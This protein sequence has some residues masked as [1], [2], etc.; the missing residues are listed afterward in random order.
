MGFC[1]DITPTCDTCFEAVYG[2]CNDVLIISLS[3]TADTTFYV[4]L[5]DKFDIITQLT[6]VTDSNGDFTITQTWT[7]YAGAMEIQIF[8]DE[9]RTNQ[10][11]FSQ[12]G[13]TFDCV[14]LQARAG[15]VAFCSNQLDFSEFCNSQ[16]AAI[17]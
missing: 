7:Q 10:V 9:A 3:L 1:R 11:N 4:D 13:T 5:I 14:V 8:S 2:V 16:Y 12:G 6:V 15:G 17:I